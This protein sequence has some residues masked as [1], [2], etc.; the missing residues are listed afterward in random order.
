MIMIRV[1][2]ALGEAVVEATAHVRHDYMGQEVDPYSVFLGRL[3]WDA[4]GSINTDDVGAW[5]Y[6]MLV[7]VDQTVGEDLGGWHALL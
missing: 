7:C 2:Q 4:T 1:Y 3:F 6:K 5:F